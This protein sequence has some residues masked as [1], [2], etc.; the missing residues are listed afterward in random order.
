VP[1]ILLVD[2]LTLMWF[3]ISAAHLKNTKCNT[4]GMQECRSLLRSGQTPA[5]EGVILAAVDGDTGE[6]HAI[7]HEYLEYCSQ[8]PGC[9]PTSWRPVG[10]VITTFRGKCCCFQEVGLYFSR[11]TARLGCFH[12][13]VSDVILQ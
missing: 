7:L 11:V 5:T 10:Y 13:L 4:T 3:D 9:R 2:I 1:N 12:H 8:G 6:I